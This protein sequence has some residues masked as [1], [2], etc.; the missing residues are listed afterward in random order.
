LGGLGNVT[1]TN[2][3]ML[4]VGLVEEESTKEGIATKPRMGNTTYRILVGEGF[5]LEITNLESPG[6]KNGP[7]V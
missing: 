4:R 5:L 7:T 1:A 2:G 6:E 3:K